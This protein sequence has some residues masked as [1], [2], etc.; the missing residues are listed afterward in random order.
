MSEDPFASTN[1]F[2]TPEPRSISF[3]VEEDP[4]S[5]G[6]FDPVD[7][8]RQPLTSSTTNMEESLLTEGI[9][10]AN[11]LVGVD[12]PEIF[13]TAYIRA[14]PIGDRVSIESLETIIGLGGLGPRLYE[15]IVAIVIPAGAMYVTRNEFNTSLA[16][17]GC[18]QKNMDV[19]LMKVYQHRNDLPV[20][21]LPNLELV[22]IKPNSKPKQSSFDDDPWRLSNSPPTPNLFPVNE[23]KKKAALNGTTMD[24]KRIVQEQ[25]TDKKISSA[26][27][28]SNLD[29]ITVT[30]AEKE[31]FLFPH[32]NYWVQSSHRQT[33]VRRRYSDFYWFWETLMKRYPFR[34]VP[35]LP[36]KRFSGKDDTFIEQ[37]C[38]GL[39]RFINCVV[40][41]PVLKNDEVVSIFL[42]EET[43]FAA[44]RKGAKLP[45]TEEEFVRV[46]PDVAGYEPLIPDDLDSRI[47][48]VKNRLPKSIERY[49]V[50]CS[51]MG[52]MIKLRQE[53][54]EQLMI[55]NKA[56]K[57]IGNI[58]QACF[59]PN[60]QA[61]PHV[62]RGY[63]SVGDYM[64]EERTIIENETSLSISGVL[65]SLK[66]HRD[67][68][69]CFIDMLE[70][71]T[72]LEV[73]QIDSLT[74][75]IASNTAK[76]N[77]H[78][79]VPGL[80]S[81]VER[82]DITIQNDTERLKYQQRRDIYI[83]YCA[84]S[85]LSYLHKQQAF[86]SLL[87]QNY[88]HQQLQFNRKTIDNWKSLEALLCDLPKPEDLA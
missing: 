24:K 63:E 9:T 2:F 18:A 73:H 82:L 85:E 39:S 19:S 69:A 12:L 46:N 88:V 65:E 40:R 81:E 3:A 32:V 22:S 79:G 45:S 87:Y 15:Q 44:W 49:D 72:R 59:V 78:R 58:E 13:D 8:I 48:V 33:S 70:R 4:W 21:L 84:A 68:L 42:T 47:E 50:L 52:R 14:G 34:V 41:H 30:V 5:S 37:R 38:Q 57:E 54:M 35:F 61:C 83:R 86:V 80:E 27:W 7:V 71:K 76:V 77:Q 75:R 11:A 66:R 20:P 55:Y 29:T 10:A 43:E 62:V 53:R 64:N 28:F 23:T 36:P 6:G 31:G 16:L 60:C 67:I 1:S 25:E 17:L 56:L 74:K 26:E 51:T